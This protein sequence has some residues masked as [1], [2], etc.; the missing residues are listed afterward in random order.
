L[1]ELETRLAILKQ[2]IKDKETDPS[3]MEIGTVVIVSGFEEESVTLVESITKQG[4]DR[5][6][7]VYVK[8]ATSG[9]R[10]E[11]LNDRQVKHAL[12]KSENGAQVH[13]S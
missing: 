12:T 8:S 13:R 7:G 5:W 1:K 3:T 9:V 2:A 10:T 11:V 6:L 4:A